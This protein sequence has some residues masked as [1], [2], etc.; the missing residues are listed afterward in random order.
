MRGQAGLGVFK[1]L[2]SLLGWIPFGI[3]TIAVWIWVLVDW[4]ISMTKAYGSA[5]RGTENLT[6]DAEGHY[7]R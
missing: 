2:L 5:Y 1:L 4:I 3:G 7:T 6:F